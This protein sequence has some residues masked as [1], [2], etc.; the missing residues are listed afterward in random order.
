[1]NKAEILKIVEKKEEEREFRK[2]CLSTNTCPKCGGDLECV[3]VWNDGG[4][5]YR[6]KICDAKFSD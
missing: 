2:R 4:H 3:T 6:C 1:M 5:E